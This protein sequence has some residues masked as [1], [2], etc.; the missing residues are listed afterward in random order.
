MFHAADPASPDYPAPVPQPV[1]AV[2][3]ATVKLPEFWQQDP[4]PWFQHVEAQFRLRGITADETRYYHVVSALDAQTTRRAMGVLRDPPAADKYGALKTLLLR[5]YR[6]SDAERAERLLSLNGLGDSRP[7]ELMENMLALLGSGDASFLFVQLFLRQLPPPVRTALA[8]SPLVATKD[9]RGLAEE[10][11]RILLATR[12]YSVQALLPTSAWTAPEELEDG[13]VA[14]VVDRRRRGGE[15][16]F[17]HRRFGTKAKRCV[18]P[19]AFP[20]QGNSSACAQ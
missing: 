19:C 8:N 12:Q 4:E 6:L 7:T 2:Y 15:L 1:P 11:D 10:A 13:A 16:C 20:G 14:A 3:A 17:Y 18:P 9:Y 5:L